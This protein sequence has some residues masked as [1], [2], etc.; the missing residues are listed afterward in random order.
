[1]LLSD[2]FDK[3]AIRPDLESET[4]EAVFHELV[5]AITAI[6][7][8]LDRDISLRA[9]QDRE[10]KLNTSIAPGIA[11]PHGY[12]PGVDGIFGALGISE[13]GIEY[14]ALDKKPVHCVF[15]VILGEACREKHLRVLNRITSLIK[16]GGLPLLRKAGSQEEIHRILSRIH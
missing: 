12:Y 11:I 10:N 4:K 7:P 14:G 6:Y 13:A 1:M 8:E 3:R 16:S 5:E 9:I 15:L 2:V